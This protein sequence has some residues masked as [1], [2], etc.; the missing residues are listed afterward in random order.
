MKPL[1]TTK[2]VA[3]LGLAPLLLSS[4][5]IDD[6]R[7]AYLTG[8]YNA[9]IHHA[10][11]ATT[12]RQWD[13]EARVLHIRALLTTGQYQHARAI[14]TNAIAKLPHSVQLHWVSHDV[15]HFNNQPQAATNALKEMNGLVSRMAW[16]YRNAPDLVVLGQMA[17]LEDVDPKIVLERLYDTAEK[18][19]PNHR[20]VPLAKG[21]L[22]LSKSDYT[23]AS[24]VFQLALKKHPKDADIH[25]G[26]AKSFEGTDRK[27]MRQH[28]M[29]AL[30]ANPNH[31]PSHL[32][33]ADNLIDREAYKEAEELLAK[34][35]KVNPEQPEAW[36]YRAVLAHLRNDKTGEKAAR[37]RA[38]KHWKRN[39]RV[40]H[41]IG[42]KLSQKYR[43]AEGSAYQ[44]QSLA[45]NDKHLPARIQLAQDLL[46]L[47]QEKEGWAMANSAHDTDGYDV[48]TFNLVTLK[49]TLDKYR[50]LKNDDFILRMTP[51]EAEI[52]GPRALALLQRA[53]DTLCK[54]Y[55]L[56]L[57]QPTTVE[58]FAEQ[59]DFGVRT[60]G[61]PDNPGFL[62]VCFGCVI[63][64]N[65]PAS[66]MP[67]PANWESVL[68]HEF[69]HTVT[70]AMT[71]NKMPRWLSEGIS[72]YEERQANP[73]WGQSMN[74]KFRE[75]ILG[76]E[77]TPVS[78]LSG[79]FLSPKT[80][81]HLSFAYYES[82]LVVEHIVD[83]F[84]LEA[85]RKIL[86]DL[87]EGVEINTAIAKHTEPMD[88][89]EPAFAAFAKTRAE[90]LA[91]KLDW[92]KPTPADLKT[93]VEAFAKRHPKNIYMLR[94]LARQALAEKKWEAAKAPCR[95]LIAL[96]P[97]Q[98]DGDNAYE[99]LANAHR[100]LKEFTEERAVL[101]RFAAMTD[102]AYDVYKRL[103]ELASEAKDW[104]AVRE[105]AERSLAVNPLL[106]PPHRHL[107]EAAEAL[108]ENDAAIGAWQ[109][110]LR[111]DPRDPAEANFRLARLLH[112]KGA[113]EAKR[114]LLMALEEAPRYREALK[115]LLKMNAEGQ[116]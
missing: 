84:G 72:V 98:T 45:F 56:T 37:E 24:R 95:E 22:A 75:M 31:I 35:L 107:A 60:F 67:D 20:A 2:L 46:R 105:N 103:M 78:K 82:S 13:E 115:L 40:P 108:K 93:G 91:P 57:E 114:H 48:T 49:D 52:Y 3:A 63:T 30:A 59:K 16:R 97:R 106:A 14:T 18:D 28:L 73:A 87:G 25:Y 33:L 79:A 39:P 12:A 66:Q 29:A 71:K 64:A 8:D 44:R 1:A 61:M 4:A 27:V 111:L 55:G 96:F 34:V 10:K 88:K 116:Q 38:L 9:T 53:K 6:A 26:V 109:T 19:D 83:R 113:P 102:D 15:F 51:R 11:A 54:K 62:G 110:V 90:A 85:I 99:M 68:W 101:Q 70:L 7:K 74:P 5:P 65:S 81:A 50:T 77:L 42:K 112:A 76:G 80:S 89:L 69:C 41:L 23:L 92:T 86:R 100:E 21:G 58:I 94:R 104:A 36:A 32:M 17:L 43:F 47:G